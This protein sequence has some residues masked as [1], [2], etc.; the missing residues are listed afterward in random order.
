MKIKKYGWIPVKEEKPEKK[1]HVLVYA[2]NFTIL[3]P[4][5]LGVY[6]EKEDSWTV[7]DLNGSIPNAEVTH[8][9]LLPEIPKD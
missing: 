4:I 7:Y 1:E 3:G 6:F 2:P 8:W 5:L 9:M